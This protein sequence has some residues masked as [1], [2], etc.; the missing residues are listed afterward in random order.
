MAKLEVAEN[1][2]EIAN[3]LSSFLS[4]LGFGGQD[5]S[6]RLPGKIAMNWLKLIE[7]STNLPT[8]EVCANLSS[9]RHKPGLRKP[10]LR[11][12]RCRVDGAL[13]SHQQTNS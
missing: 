3:S 11:K 4:D 8:S 6:Y 7:N 10:Y 1:E 12:H 2:S 9:T 13:E 5:E